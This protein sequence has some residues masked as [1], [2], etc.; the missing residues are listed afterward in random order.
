MPDICMETCKTLQRSNMYR[1]SLH[2]CAAVLQR[3]LGLQINWHHADLIPKE[4]HVLVSNHLTAG[5]LMMLY[6]L[7]QHYVHLI[8]AKLPKR[9]SQARSCQQHL[10]LLT[11]Q[12]AQIS[13]GKNA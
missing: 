4:R 12:A 11:I 7:P 2:D 3:L 13:T 1:K 5:D 9:I 6:S 10:L 8:S